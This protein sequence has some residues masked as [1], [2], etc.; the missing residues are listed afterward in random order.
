MRTTLLVSM[1]L[2]LTAMA[3]Q[4]KDTKAP[5]GVR[6]AIA[7]TRA[8]MVLPGDYTLCQK[9]VQNTPKGERGEMDDY[10]Y[11]AVWNT[12]QARL[13]ACEN[14]GSIRT[15]LDTMRPRWSGNG[16]EILETSEV[17]S[18][19]GPCLLVDLKRSG[20]FPGKGKPQKYNRVMQGVWGDDVRLLIVEIVFPE[21]RVDE[22][23]P[24]LLRAMNG[25]KWDR[26]AALL[27]P[28]TDILGMPVPEGLR[29]V[30]SGA[31]FSSSGLSGAHCPAGP[32][33]W[34]DAWTGGSF[35]VPHAQELTH[36]IWDGLR[37]ED[38][39]LEPSSEFVVAGYKAFEIVSSGT[40]NLK[41]YRCFT[42]VINDPKKTRSLFCEGMVPEAEAEVML[43]RLRAAVR[44]WKPVGDVIWRS[45]HY[46]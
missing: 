40:C 13:C 16:V 34:F 9:F 2:S 8:T 4:P 6:V 36:R 39:A 24:A 1:G 46:R 44:A 7:R 17:T 35:S 37:A 12:W 41:R 10:H 27:P 29:W 15:Y 5:D 25:L 33:S 11:A 30:G 3:Q 45:P 43:P 14:E 20:P 21:A 23:R 18:E 26:E 28:A 19:A 31:S 22:I 32:D 38:V 42:A